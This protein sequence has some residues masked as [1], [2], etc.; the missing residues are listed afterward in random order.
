[1]SQMGLEA[2]KAVRDLAFDEFGAAEA[3]VGDGEEGGW[4][5]E[6]APTALPAPSGRHRNRNAMRTM[7]TMPPTM[8]TSTPGVLRADLSLVC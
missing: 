4:R 6:A 3:D 8:V 2:A 5:R 1:M 7:R